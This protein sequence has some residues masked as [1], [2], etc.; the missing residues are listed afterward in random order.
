MNLTALKLA[1]IVSDIEEF[2]RHTVRFDDRHSIVD[3]VAL[4]SAAETLRALRV[5]GFALTDITTNLARRVFEEP[6][7]DYLKPAAPGREKEIWR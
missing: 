2:V 3:N 1:K 5:E 4:D 6:P 7:G